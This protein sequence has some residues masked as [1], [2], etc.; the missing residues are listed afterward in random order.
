MKLAPLSSEAWREYDAAVVR[1]VAAKPRTSDFEAAL[2][3][4]NAAEFALERADSLASGALQNFE[5][6]AILE[7]IPWA[8]RGRVRDEVL[9]AALEAVET[10]LATPRLGEL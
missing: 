10:A 3:T 5:I 7:G 2:Q 1:F 9:F 6:A 4:L 8:L